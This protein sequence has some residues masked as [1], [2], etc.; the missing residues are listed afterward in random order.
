MSVYT[1]KVER[2]ERELSQR[3]LLE[4]KIADLGAKVADLQSEY[5]IMLEA[6]QL[7][8]TVSDENANRVLVYMQSVINRVLGELFKYDTPR[9]QL[10]K[11]L[12]Q[13]QKPHITVQ[14]ITESG[15]KRDLV[16]QTGTGLRQI[17]SF[18]FTLCLIEI[19]KG[20]K[21]LIMDEI[22][23]GLHSE[24][25]KAIGEIMKIFEEEGFQFIMVEHGMDDIGRFYL[26]EKPGKTAVVNHYEG[27]RY[28]GEV[29]LFS[30]PDE[31]VA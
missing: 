11:Y 15:E 7:L 30:K 23:N 22:L 13:G 10:D 27:D 29:F 20:R 4:K 9:I 6:Q 25:K 21:L 16:F 12:W 5:D 8:S 14:L 3:L 19:Y 2:L 24:A 1:A 31:E 26:V 28:N 17:I 18:L